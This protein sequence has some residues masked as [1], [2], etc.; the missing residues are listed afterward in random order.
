MTEMQFLINIEQND[1]FAVIYDADKGPQRFE[2]NMFLMYSH[3][4]QHSEGCKE[5]VNESTALIPESVK[6]YA[7]NLVN[8]LKGIYGPLTLINNLSNLK[9]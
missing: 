6:E 7:Q 2:Q 9:N 1:I 4:G 8:E 3:I 5:Y